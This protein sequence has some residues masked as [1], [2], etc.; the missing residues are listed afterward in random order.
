[1]RGTRRR[2]VLRAPV[3]IVG[4]ICERCGAP[5]VCY[6][7]PGAPLQIPFDT[8]PLPDVTPVT[9]AEYEV[10]GVVHWFTCDGGRAVVE[11]LSHAGAVQ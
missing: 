9:P 11:R 4:G 5:V 7:R 8:S 10:Y 6:G 3:E 1:M 2:V